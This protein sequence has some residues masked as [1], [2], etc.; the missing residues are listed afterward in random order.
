VL[1][2]VFLGLCQLLEKGGKIKTGVERWRRV[3][4]GVVEYKEVWQ[5]W[6]SVMEWMG[7]WCRWK[8]AVECGRGL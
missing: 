4:I 7:V 5:M 6:R 2:N 8:S 1:I 3:E